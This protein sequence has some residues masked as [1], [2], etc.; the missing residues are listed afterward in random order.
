MFFNKSEEIVA[1]KFFSIGKEQDGMN[2]Q[3]LVESLLELFESDFGELPKEFVIHGPY[4]IPKG[5][6]IGIRA[7][8]NKLKLKGHE[9]YY[10]LSGKTDSKLGLE[11]CN[12]T[13]LCSINYLFYH[14][15]RQ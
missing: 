10:A 9:K 5:R 14:P 2:R 6:H 13:V 1:F 15:A 4:G 7:F 11:A 3:A 8:K 12:S